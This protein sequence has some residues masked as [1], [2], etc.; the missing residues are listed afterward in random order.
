MTYQEQLSEIGEQLDDDLR[1]IRARL[2]ALEKR[3]SGGGSGNVPDEKLEAIDDALDR[4]VDAIE[5]MGVD[6]QGKWLDLGSDDDEGTKEITTGQGVAI[7]ALTDLNGVKVELSGNSR[8]TMVELQAI[9]DDGDVSEVL[10]T[11]AVGDD[12]RATLR[13]SLEAEEEYNVLAHAGGEQY[14]R[15]RATDYPLPKANDD[16]EVIRGVYTSTNNRT[17]HGRYNIGRIAGYYG[18]PSK[19]ESEE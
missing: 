12:G 14:Q 4:L 19:A 17:D 15:G 6:P 18:N 11:A 9:D 1:E 3:E 16:L 10:D 2:N 5:N 13:G 7:E 8:A